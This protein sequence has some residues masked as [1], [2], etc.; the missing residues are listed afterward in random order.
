MVDAVSS[1]GAVEMQVDRWNV[2]V[3]C[4]SPQKC[5]NGPQG[6]AIVSVSKKAWQKIRARDSSIS[7]LC[8]D[9]NVWREYHNGVREAYQNGIWSDISTATSKAIH[10]PS[11]S[12]S[13]VAGL[14]AA[15]NALFDE[16][17]E[18]VYFRHVIAGKAV[19]MGVR[20]MGLGVLAQEEVAAP[21]S[22][23]IIFD[24]DI[25]W[26][27]LA[28]QSFHDNQMAL[29]SGFRIGTMGQSANPEWVLEALD[30]LKHS[31]F[32]LGYSI[33]HT[34]FKDVEMLFQESGL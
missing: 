11:P 20:S 22:T 9:L 6:L 7:T 28:M 18:N 31:L 2:D 5:L 33:K 34:D 10:G 30:R 14:H 26:T 1:V 12:Y 24:P 19:R 17:V 32:K 16:G 27:R 25:D 29:A 21:V 3:C 15:I 13:L 4:T 23:R 8:L